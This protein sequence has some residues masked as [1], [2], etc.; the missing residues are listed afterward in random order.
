MSSPNTGGVAAASAFCAV[1]CTPSAR[2]AHAPPARSATAVNASPLVLTASIVASSR[3]RRAGCR[4]S[5]R[6]AAASP[7]STAPVATASSRIGRS[8]LPTRSD[9]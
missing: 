2:P 4:Q 9:Q 6:V 7:A 3:A 8:R 1:F 5:A